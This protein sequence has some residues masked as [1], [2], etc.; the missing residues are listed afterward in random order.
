MTLFAKRGHNEGGITDLLN[1][2]PVMLKARKSTSI[3]T[4]HHNNNRDNNKHV[5]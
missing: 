2:A 1:T 3:I 4:N 5:Y